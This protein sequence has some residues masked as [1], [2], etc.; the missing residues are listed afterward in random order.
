VKEDGTVADAEVVRSSGSHRL[1][2]AAVQVVRKRFRY[3]PAKDPAGNPIASR[4]QTRIAF[5]LRGSDFARQRRN[6]P[7]PASCRAEPESSSTP[8]TGLQFLLNEDGTVGRALVLNKTGWSEM[9]V[10]VWARDLR[11]E[12]SRDW[13]GPCWVAFSAE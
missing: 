2:E 1:D 5:S 12:K 9:P 6:M 4:L 3:S 11:Y 10:G 8:G 7:L 13:T